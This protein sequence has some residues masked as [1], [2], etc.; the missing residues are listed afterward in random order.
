MD[1]KRL[2]DNQIKCALTEEE[3]KEMGFSID[4]II[5]NGEVT[6]KFMRVVLEKV[7]EQEEIDIE[8]LSP[9]VRA[10]LLPDHSMSITFGG[11]TEEE[12]KGMFG[13]ILEMMNQMAG[14]NEKTT[15]AVPELKQESLEKEEVPTQLALGFKTI[16]EAVR[17]SRLFLGKDRMPQS[18]LYKM[19][20]K[21]Y[22]IMKFKNFSN[23][24]LKPMAFTAVEYG[25][26]RIADAAGIAFIG[27]HGKCILAENALENLAQI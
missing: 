5:G 1:I 4:D 21:Y 12:K 15:E 22:L 8:L 16:E 23:Q 10:E 25:N 7:E 27:E 3:I 20:E 13:K 6:Q 2:S 26:D 9:M 18:S 24:D 19:N 11:I 14:K 17:I